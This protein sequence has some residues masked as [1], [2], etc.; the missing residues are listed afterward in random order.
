MSSE[1]TELAAAPPPSWWR[2]A[3][4][5]L[6]GRRHDYTTESLDRA[7]L[8]LAVPMVLEMLAES[9]FAVVD[10]YWVSRLGSEAV[11]VVG[12]TEAV[13]TLIYAVAIGMSFAATAIVARYVGRAGSGR[14]AAQIAGQIITAGMIASTV[15]GMTLCWFAADI[16]RLLGGERVAELGTGFAQVMFAGNLSVFLMF[17]I[18]AIFRGAGDPAIAMRALWLANGINMLLAPCLIFGWGPFPETGVIGAALATT[19]SRGIGVLYQLGHLCGARSAIGVGL[20]HLKPVAAELRLVTVTALSGIA[21]M[22]VSTTSGIG[23]FS[24]AALSGTAALAGCAIALRVVQ[25]FLMPALGLAHSGATLVGQNLGAGNPER[26][27]AAV[28]IAARYN[29]IF[30]GSIGVLLFVLAPWIV[31]LFSRE[32]AVVDE[33]TLALRIVVIAF[34][35]YAAG[36]C[37]QAA[38][39]G[40]GDTWTAARLNFFCFWIVQVPLAWVLAVVLEMGATGVYLSVPIAFGLLTGLAALLF[41]RG[42]WKKHEL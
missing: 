37:L 35:Y 28:R 29:M 1:A 7:V 21:Q 23:L 11:A 42:R 22:V 25:F 17:L 5:A 16:L 8:L 2:I 18:N 36:M 13:M 39:N 34:P 9:V 32:L 31:T 15:V 4:L 40:A 19:I 30:L 6:Q 20:R 27:V 3:I 12:L 33:A 10:T 38:F 41:L 24:I 26:A 14:A